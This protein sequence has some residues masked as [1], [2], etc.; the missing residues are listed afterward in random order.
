MA[1][2]YAAVWPSCVHLQGFQLW[3]YMSGTQKQCPCAVIDSTTCL[4]FP[5]CRALARPSAV[6][7]LLLL[8]QMAHILHAAA[9]TCPYAHTHQ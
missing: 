1:A 3:C 2:P 7:H 8:T 4:A 9:S 6:M 5:G